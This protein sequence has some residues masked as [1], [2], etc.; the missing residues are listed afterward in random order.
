MPNSTRFIGLDVHKETVAAA[1]AEADGRVSS[2]GVIPNEPEAIARLMR[3]LGPPSQLQVAYEA[4]PCGYVLYEQLQKMGISC[5]VAAPSLIPV[6]AGDRVKTDRRD[7]LKLA[8]C[9][10]NGDLVPVWVPDQ[11]QRDLRELVRARESAL[12][13][14][15]RARHRLQLFL[16][17]QGIRP[18]SAMRTGSQP[19]QKWLQSL[20]MPSAALQLAL[21]D[22]LAQLVHQASRLQALEQAVSE[23]EASAEPAQQAL[24]RA[25]C[26]L[27]GVKELT[28]AT[29]AAEVG[30]LHRF[31][32]APQ[33]MSYAGLVPSEHSSGGPSGQRRGRITKAGNAHVRRVV[34]E[35]AWSYSR[36][37]RT[38]GPV[39][40]RRRG[41]DPL[42]VQIALKAQSRLSRKYARLVAK[43][44]PSNRAATA[45]ARELLGFMWAIAGRVQGSLACAESSAQHAAS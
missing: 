38:S 15:K 45:V 28:A 36:P 2:L 26:C 30:P 39:A 19:Y 42:V 22:L 44:V 14:H 27:R 13:D 34:L 8:R 23:A 6:R 25:L 37:A 16:L 18:P 3:R 41:Q 7:A 40:Q 31:D 29:I 5:L 32:K 24:I 1:V 12:I 33:L 17:R 43:G 20:R 4:G 11:A 9:L 10:R 35:A 21:S